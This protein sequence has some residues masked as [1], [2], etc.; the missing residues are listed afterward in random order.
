MGA[1]LK[2]RLPLGRRGHRGVGLKFSK[3]RVES[4]AAHA[5]LFCKRPESLQKLLKAQ[6]GDCRVVFWRGLA[7][8]Q[9][10]APWPANRQHDHGACPLYVLLH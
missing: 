6:G 8:R 10:K 5:V 1:A 9:G 3:G 2:L 4:R 7:L